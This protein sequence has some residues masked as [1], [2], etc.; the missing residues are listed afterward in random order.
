[1]ALCSYY[2]ELNQKYNFN[3]EINMTPVVKELIASAMAING[4]ADNNELKEAVAKLDALGD[5]AKGD[6]AEYKAL[7]AMVD[8]IKEDEAKAEALRIAEEEANTEG[9]DDMNILEAF[10]VAERGGKFARR[11]WC[12]ELSEH[13]VFIERG[14]TLPSLSNGTHAS[15]YQPSIV[16]VMAKDWY[17]VE[18][19][20]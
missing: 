16:D 17:N 6:T 3:K 19:E 8:A 12:D 2:N 7:K 1:M 20:V 18:E 4:Y 5:N 10:A 11:E 9:H 14:H 13:Y 15:P